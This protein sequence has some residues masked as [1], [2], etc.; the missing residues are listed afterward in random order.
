M[1]VGCD[2]L[3]SG[4]TAVTG[5][6]VSP[7]TVS[8]YVGEMKVLY[9]TV[10]PS[11]AT[12]KAVTWTSDAPAI[13]TV[14]DNGTV[15]ALSTGT[16]TVTVTTTD[17]S[18]K[19]N[20]IITVSN[21][22]VSLGKDS[23]SLVQGETKFLEATITPYSSVSY[24]WASSDESIVFV[25]TGNLSAKSAGKATITATANDFGSPKG[26]CEVTVLPGG[27]FSSANHSATGTLSATESARWH[28]LYCTPGNDYSINWKEAFKVTAYGDAA[29]T[30]TLNAAS[31]SSFYLT[32][33]TA[34]TVYFKVESSDGSYSSYTLMYKINE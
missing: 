9:D 18:Y 5:V 25:G 23:L 21:R 34:R 29:G 8:M 15:K 4:G 11:G 24:T 16:A 22:V 13:A 27:A 1:L 17:G 19:A 33:T 20:S 26:T 10:T 2:T 6:T 31:T 30:E 28:T 3:S 14:S 12:N 32:V 7:E